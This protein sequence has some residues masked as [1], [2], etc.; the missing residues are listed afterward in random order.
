MVQLNKSVT[1]SPGACGGPLELN[2]WG[3]GSRILH[4]CNIAAYYGIS[5]GT[6]SWIAHR[7]QLMDTNFHFIALLP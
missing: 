2:L 5:V 7:C 1:D 6:Q 4:Q 3:E